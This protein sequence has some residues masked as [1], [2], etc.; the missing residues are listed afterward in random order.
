IPKLKRVR[1]RHLLTH[2]IGHDEGLM[3]SK[4]IKDRDQD[5][6]L[7]YIWNSKIVHEPGQYFVY[8]NA[9]P[10][11]ISALIQEELGVNLSQWINDLLF[12]PLG[13]EIFE[14]KNYGKYCAASSG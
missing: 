4:D 3:F 14:W 2:T 1:L 6:L 11:L 5:N 7:E 13:I 12:E 9:G 8:S 10:Y